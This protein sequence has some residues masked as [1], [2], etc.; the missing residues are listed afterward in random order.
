MLQ[1]AKWG[2]RKDDRTFIFTPLSIPQIKYPRAVSSEKGQAS[3]EGAS[4][5][6]AGSP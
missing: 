2:K 1:R 6:Q 5:D 3:L 4:L